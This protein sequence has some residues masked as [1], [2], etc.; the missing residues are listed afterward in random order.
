MSRLTNREPD[1]EHH[2]ADRADRPDE[3]ESGRHVRGV[4]DR[5]E[6]DRAGESPEDQAVDAEHREADR[7]HLGRRGG[8]EGLVD[9]DG[10]RCER[11]ACQELQ[12]H[13]EPERMHVERD[14][15]EARR[16]P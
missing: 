7:P 9:R 15:E 2:S 11:S 8:G 4:A 16:T 3:G 5:T 1:D 13:H 6:Q 10:K 14:G 12:Q